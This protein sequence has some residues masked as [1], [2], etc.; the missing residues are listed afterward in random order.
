MWRGLSMV[1]ST[2]EQQ[3]F[4]TRFE[5][6]GGELWNGAWLVPMVTR[7][8]EPRAVMGVARDITERKLL[9]EQLRQA[10]K[11]EAIGQL[12]GGIAHDFNNL[13]TTILGYSDIASRSLS[14]HDPDPQRT[15]RRSSRP[16][17]GPANLTRQLL[18]FSRK[19]GLRAAGPRP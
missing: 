7:Q 4:E 10:Q 2:R 16:A 3:Y 14:P 9:E 11:M 19:A 12:A 18:A 17:S 6:P 5:A 8:G 15:S 1:F 13:L